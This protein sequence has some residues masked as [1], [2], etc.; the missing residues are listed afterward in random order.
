LTPAYNLFGHVTSGMEIALEIE[1][2]DV[3]ETVEIEE[4]EAS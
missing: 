3:M 2:G 4:I 1:V